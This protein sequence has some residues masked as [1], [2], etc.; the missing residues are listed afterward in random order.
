MLTLVSEVSGFA[1]LLYVFVGF[2][3]RKL[4][5]KKKLEATLLENMRPV[6]YDSQKAGNVDF[7]EPMTLN[8][9]TVKKILRAT[10]KK[11]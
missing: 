11:F 7:H 6:D 3:L 1:D 5:T 8:P 10:K 4:Y 9:V 2:F